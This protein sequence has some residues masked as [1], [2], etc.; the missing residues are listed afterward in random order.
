MVSKNEHGYQD[1]ALVHRNTANYCHLVLQAVPGCG[2]GARVSCVDRI[3]AN[4]ARGEDLG[5]Y[6]LWRGRGCQGEYQLAGAQVS[7]RVFTVCICI[8]I[9]IRLTAVW[10]EREAAPGGP[11]E[12]DI[13]GGARGGEG[14]RWE[15]S[16]VVGRQA[17]SVLKRNREWMQRNG[18]EVCICNCICICICICAGRYRQ[19]NRHRRRHGGRQRGPDQQLPAGCGGLPGSFLSWMNFVFAS[20]YNLQSDIAVERDFIVGKMMEY[21]LI[22]YVIKKCVINK[23]S[24]IKTVFHYQSSMVLNSN[25][26]SI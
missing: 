2:L 22:D 15:G 17:V 6:T 10:R 14:G 18:V 26:G 16:A 1:L 20:V 7:C 5:G 24:L 12:P 9:C 13:P 3:V 8:C 11:V 21:Q 25:D 19:R 4:E 23:F